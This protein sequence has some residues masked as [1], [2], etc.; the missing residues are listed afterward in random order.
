MLAAGAD[1]APTGP[2]PNLLL[3]LIT[4]GCGLARAACVMFLLLLFYW[5]SEEFFSDKT[6]SLV[7]YGPSSR[8]PSVS[9]CQARERTPSHGPV[10]DPLWPDN[11]TLRDYLAIWAP[12]LTDVLTDVTVAAEDSN[13]TQLELPEGHWHTAV[14]LP[15]QELSEIVCFT[16]EVRATGATAI[17]RLELR[18]RRLPGFTGPWLA[19]HFVPLL[20]SHVI[21]ADATQKKMELVK[22][23]WPPERVRSVALSVT[24]HHLRY[25]DRPR[26]PCANGAGRRHCL[27][28][29]RLRAAAAAAGC[30]P[31]FVSPPSAAEAELPDCGSQDSYLEFVARFQLPADWFV[32]MYLDTAEMMIIDERPI[33]TGADLV[34]DVGGM[35]GLLLG[36]SVFTLIG[37]L[38]AALRAV[39]R[40]LA[41]RDRWLRRLGGPGGRRA[42]VAAAGALGRQRRPSSAPAPPLPHHADAGGL[43]TISA[44]APADVG[45]V[46]TTL[47]PRHQPHHGTEPARAPAKGGSAGRRRRRGRCSTLGSTKT[48]RPQFSQQEL[49]VPGAWG[50][51][52]PGAQRAVRNGH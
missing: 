18:G 51:P 50:Q 35:L 52:A 27:E 5:K 21:Y 15:G 28:R 49:L 40:R 33:T 2:S 17:E 37:Q 32:T 25:L 48:L 41:A 10:D 38:E 44:T 22:V 30:L 42:M 12:A 11:G 9:V 7:S 4:A 43:T 6:T 47:T 3:T 46:F 8:L 26:R 16:T 45:S 29:S 39:V 19:V 34:A 31:H 20:H 13:G 14:L 1:R 36:Y 23:F 24:W